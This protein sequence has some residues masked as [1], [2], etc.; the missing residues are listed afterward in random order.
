MGNGDD[1]E[2]TLH[3]NCGDNDTPLTRG[4][5]ILSSTEGFLLTRGGVPK[6]PDHRRHVQVEERRMVPTLPPCIRPG[7][8]HIPTFCGPR[9]FYRI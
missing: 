9:V 8:L 2:K 5:K 6:D 7:S 1:L 4:S 3:L